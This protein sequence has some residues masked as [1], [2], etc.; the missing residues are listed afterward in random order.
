MV[1]KK[2]FPCS[3]AVQNESIGCFSDENVQY[4]KENSRFQ[5][6]SF[7]ADGPGVKNSK[8]I[9]KKFGFDYCNVP[10]KYLTEGIKDW[11]DLVRIH[12]YDPVIEYLKK[13]K[14]I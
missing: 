11:S 6:L 3:C 14:L 12:G 13:R 2:I 7:D 10:R 5:V 1:M 8:L 4:L 9:T